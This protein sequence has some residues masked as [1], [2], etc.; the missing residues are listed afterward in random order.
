MIDFLQACDAFERYLDGFDR[1]SERISLKTVHTQGVVNY[2]SAIAGKMGLSK[3]DQELAKLIALLHDIGRFEQVKR[4]DSFEPYTMD[5][6][7]F[8]VELLFDEKENGPMIRQF[9]KDDQ[10]DDIIRTAIACHSS[11]AL[12]SIEDAHT[13]LHA[14]LIRDAD[15][16]DNC[17]VKL[18]ESVE[19]LLG[20]P[21][22]LIGNQQI[23]DKVW[24][25]C[26]NHQSVFSQ[27]RITKMDYWV[28]YLAYF[29]DINFRESL[30]IIKKEQFIQRIIARIPYT[31]RNTKCKMAALE[32][33][34]L[35]L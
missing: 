27:A 6:A 34:L 33:I 10:W 24:Q 18:E 17:R 29:F 16:L 32:Q 9:I 23:S 1:T 4:Y 15:K 14:K 20:M 35:E 2:A 3:E 25:Y 13:D 26:L 8:G 7:G 28:S 22:Q 21:A 31:N 30:S 11:Y 19:V 5:H 12:P